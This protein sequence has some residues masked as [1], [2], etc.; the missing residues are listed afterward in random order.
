MARVIQS[1]ATRG[2]QK[3]IQKLINEK[4]DILNKQLQTNLNIQEKTQVAFSTQ[5]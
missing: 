3:W 4:P 2:S 5:E 1:K